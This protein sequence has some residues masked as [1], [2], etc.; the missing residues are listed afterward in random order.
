MG[1]NVQA[2]VKSYL[3]CQMDKTEKKKV[4]RLL[5]PLPIPKKPW[6]S[7]S[8]DFIIGF[9]KVCDFKSIFVVVDRFSKY[10][11]FIPAP[12]AYLAEEVARLFFIHVMKHFGLPRDIVSDQDARFTG[13]FWIELFKHLGSKLKFFTANH[14]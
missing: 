11:V 12:N 6:E 13:Y 5:Q 10:L 4:T 9:P 7:I 2:Y 8:M 1:K 14:P 3:V